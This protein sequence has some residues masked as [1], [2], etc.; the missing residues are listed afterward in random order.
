MA[1]TSRRRQAPRTS[2][3]QLWYTTAEAADLLRQSVY[4]IRNWAEWR[5]PRQHLRRLPNGLLF[6]RAFVLDPVLL[7]VRPAPASTAQE[8]SNGDKSD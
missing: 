3:E 4:T 5:V 7:T 1:S 8:T 6:S 2:Q